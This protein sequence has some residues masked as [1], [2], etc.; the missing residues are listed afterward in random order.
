MKKKETENWCF[1]LYIVRRKTANVSILNERTILCG[2]SLLFLLWCFINVSP[3]ASHDSGWCLMQ[4]F[5]RL[6]LYVRL[7]KKI[8]IKL[9]NYMFFRVESGYTK[10]GSVLIQD[11]KNGPHMSSGWGWLTLVLLESFLKNTCNAF[12]RFPIR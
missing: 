5:A 1:P 10:K 9:Q 6:H 12:F 11:F 7:F 4:H 2:R 3:I 8:Y